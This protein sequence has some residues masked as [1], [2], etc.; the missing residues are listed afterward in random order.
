MTRVECT[1]SPI[2]RPGGGVKKTVNTTTQ[3]RFRVELTKND[4]LTMLRTHDGSRLLPPDTM[5]PE[6]DSQIDVAVGPE[7]GDDRS[8][9]E[10]PLVLTWT[11]TEVSEGSNG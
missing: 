9:D 8:L 3:R 1:L 4:V 6:R 7:H 5:L 11:T 2:A 10:Y